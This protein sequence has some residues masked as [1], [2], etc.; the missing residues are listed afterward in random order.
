MLTTS[1]NDPTDEDVDIGGN[2]APVTS[3]PPVQ[4][5]KDAGGRAE[6]CNEAGPDSDRGSECSKDSSAV[7]QVQDDI[8]QTVD[9]EEKGDADEMVDG[10]ASVSGLD[11]LEQG[12]QLRPY[13]SDSDG[14]LDGESSQAERQVSPDKLYR[15]ALLKN[16]F[17]DTILKAREKTLN[18][19]D[20][21]DPERLRRERE[22][23]E[24]HKRR[25]KARLQA[26]A[27]A[28]EDARKQAE[29]EAAAEAK[30]RRELEREA[31]REA[32]LKM[33]K[34]VEINENSRFLE[35]LE[36]LRAVAPEQLPSSVDETSPDHSPD[37]FG[38]FKFGGSNPLEQLG[39]YMK[40]DDEEEEV[41]PPSVPNAI[42][43]V[44]EG[45]ID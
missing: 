6:E 30:R 24:M 26:E 42:D 20:K 21:A 31:A 2:E 38:S 43:D 18:Q 23:L 41:D 4:I 27:R 5:D 9:S 3:Y 36:M 10:H 33:E 13:S 14:Q 37:G 40:V 17:A 11:Q 28:A 19:D 12:S 45:E 32:L 8:G 29:A 25:E 22:E 39:L 44:E 34:T 1:G 7:K 35:D 15:A 16:R